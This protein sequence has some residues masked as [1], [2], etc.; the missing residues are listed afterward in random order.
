MYRERGVDDLAR[1]FCRLL[2]HQ[3]AQSFSRNSVV[4]GWYT[5]NKIFLLL[6]KF[7]LC[8]RTKVDNNKNLQLVNSSLV[9]TEVYL[10][11]SFKYKKNKQFIVFV[12]VRD[13]HIF[14]SV[15]IDI[16]A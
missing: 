8:V 16:L 2:K 3:A 6:D 13:K 12:F 1:H 14:R 11:K 15:R 5:M 10:K 4:R 7:H 9:I